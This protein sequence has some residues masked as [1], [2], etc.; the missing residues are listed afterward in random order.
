MNKF[1]F[2]DIDG[3]LVTSDNVVP[4]SAWKAIEE[5]RAN[6]D[7][8]FIC[9]GRNRPS[10]EKITGPEMDGTIYNT[11]AG[12]YTRQHGTVQFPISDAV[13]KELVDRALKAKVGF[14]FF[15]ENYAYGDEIAMNSMAAFGRDY[16]GHSPEE[17]FAIYSVKPLDCY[18]GQPV[19]KFDFYFPNEE[20]CRNFTEK[21]DESIV[22]N[23]M[24]AAGVIY[25]EVNP[26][27]ISKGSA[28]LEILKLYGGSIEDTY[29]FGDSMND[30]GMIRT[31]GH[32]IGMGNAVQALKDMSEY[33][34]DPVTEDGVANAMR[35]YGLIH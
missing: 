19:M 14:M 23:Q 2:F 27:G 21:F 33:V 31:C 7:Y 35:H 10:A 9:S 12:I 25:G 18:E 32:S 30:E 29:G 8:C 24:S 5:C 26:K 3:T 11:G 20:V 16:G 6:G 22:W 34:T 15:T 17:T 1:L 28:V 4:E 13:V